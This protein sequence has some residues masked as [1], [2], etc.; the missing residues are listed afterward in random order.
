MFRASTRTGSRASS[1]SRRPAR[2]RPGGGRVEIAFLRVVLSESRFPP[3]SSPGQAFRDHA[4]F[5]ERRL[6]QPERVLARPFGGTREEAEFAALRV[7]QQRRRHAERPAGRL[8]VLEN[9]R[10]RIGVVAEPL[11]PTSLSQVFG[12]SRLRV[13][14][15]TATTSNL[16]PP[17]FACSASSAG[18]SLRHGTHHVAHRFNSTVRPRKSAS[19]RGLP[20]L[21]AKARSGRRFGSDAMPTAA[22]SPRASGARRL[23]S[24]GSRAAGRL[25]RFALHPADP[26]YRRKPERG[27]RDHESDQGGPAILAFRFGRSVISELLAVGS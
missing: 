18:I 16:S 17:S 25:D 7:D 15:L 27:A 8:E 26:V 14:M 1:A 4:S 13:S 24:R 10:A 23:R 11:I 22:T 19:V 21:S 20:S 2:S 6:D 12:L 3:G 5:P 9:L